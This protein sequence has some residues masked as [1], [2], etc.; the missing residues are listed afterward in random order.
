M[1]KNTGV[2]TLGG[3]IS[4]LTG[5]NFTQMLRHLKIS[6]ILLSANAPRA[7]RETRLYRYEVKSDRFIREFYERTE[8][9][10]TLMSLVYNRL[11]L[12]FNS[13]A[14][15][16][17]TATDLAPERSAQQAVDAFRTNYNVT[18]VYPGNFL[19]PNS[20]VLPK[21]VPDP[22]EQNTTTA[23]RPLWQSEHMRKFVKSDV[24]N[25]ISA[26]I[27][28][29]TS[30]ASAEYIDGSTL[31]PTAVTGF[32]N[33]GTYPEYKLP[34]LSVE[35]ESD[36]FGGYVIK[37][38]TGEVIEEINPTSTDGIPI[39]RKMY[40]IS[41]VNPSAKTLVNDYKSPPAY[42]KVLS[43]TD[44]IG[45]NGEPLSL[46]SISEV[47]NSGLNYDYAHTRHAISNF[48]KALKYPIRALKDCSVF[49]NDLKMYIKCAN[50]Y[51]CTKNKQ[52]YGFCK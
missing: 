4:G 8:N 50:H 48:E 13:T 28:Q 39:F 44:G 12:G 9:V 26:G 33:H 16:T 20:F 52:A 31:V 6:G 34:L 43:G 45:E 19:S 36:D 18:Y 30:R 23:T 3:L 40:E 38:P 51:R 46:K 24:F 42:Y 27:T 21:E 2:S 47:G 25:E 35:I 14:F 22:A 11:L 41:N 17:S 32:D 1:D 7:E 37:Q 5:G 49:E 10:S 15:R 29:S